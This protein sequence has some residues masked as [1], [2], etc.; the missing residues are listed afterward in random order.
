[1]VSPG[2]E[3]NVY[4]G[5]GNLPS[6]PLPTMAGTLPFPIKFGYQVVGRVEAAGEGAGFEPGDLVFAAHPHPDVFTMPAVF[7][8]KLPSDIDTVRAGFLNMC[9][10]PL[11]TVHDATIR[12]GEVVVFSCLGIIAIL[13]AN[14]LRQDA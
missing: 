4:R 2:S 8:V 7:G 3:M 13:T 14:L 10:V 9:T 6:V 1:M 12:V 5:E 11:R